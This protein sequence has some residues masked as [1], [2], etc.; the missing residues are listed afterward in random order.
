M[1]I[2]EKDVTQNLRASLVVAVDTVNKASL[3]TNK[4]FQGGT[5][6]R[7]VLETSMSDKAAADHLAIQ[8]KIESGMNRA[9]AIAPYDSDENFQAWFSSLKQAL[10]ESIQ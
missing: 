4:A 1:D 6:A 5:A 9:E 3:Y 2:E 10:N 8:D 7:G